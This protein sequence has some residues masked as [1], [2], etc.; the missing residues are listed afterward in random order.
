MNPADSL[1]IVSA[2]AQV[3][4]VRPSGLALAFAIGRELGMGIDALTRM[5][6]SDVCRHLG[7][8]ASQAR[9]FREFLEQPLDRFE[10]LASRGIRVTTQLDALQSGWSARLP[11]TPWLFFRGDLDLLNQPAIGFSGSRDAIDEA[12]DMSRRIAI[13]AINHGMS[14]VSGGARGVDLS[15]HA[16]ALDAGGTTVVIVPQGLDTWWAP[17]SLADPANRGRLLVVSAD[18]PWAP[19]TTVSAMQRNRAIVDLSDVMTIPQAG[20]TGGSHSTGMFALRQQRDLWVADLGDAAPG[21]QLLLKR[22]AQ[23]IPMM[24]GMPDIARMRAPR[25]TAPA[26]QPLF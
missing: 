2:L 7:W 6:E 12:I 16:A 24:D 18:L 26:Q 13:E 17:P 4:G 11:S 3:P 5:P 25:P 23:P 10:V 20:I 9:S 19:W 21:N 1:R 8:D 15:A 14:V 22:G